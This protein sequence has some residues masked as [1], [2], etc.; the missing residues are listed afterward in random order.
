M[1]LFKIYLFLYL[2]GFLIPQETTHPVLDNIDLPVTI[3]HQGGNKEYPDQSMLAFDNSVNLGIQ[4]LELDIHRTMDS[5]LVIH[6]DASIDRL[7]NQTGMIKEMTWD[8]LQ[9][10]DG[11]YNW[12]IN[13]ENYPYRGKGVQII[14][15]AQLIEKYPDKVYDIEIKQMD[16]PIETDLCAMLRKY[17]LATD[18]VIVASFYDD[19][20]NQFHNICPEVAISLSVKKGTKLYILSRVGLE[21]LLP[22]N[23]VIAQLPLQF[24]SPIG[25]LRLDKRYINAFSK[26]DRQVWVWTVDDPSKMEE[27]LDMGVHGILTDRPDVLMNVTQ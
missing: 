7:T 9:D 10:V 21:R 27:V 4:I 1:T 17:D 3:A 13:G 2:F 19:I 12:T 26:G 15:L 23:S 16:P 14:S 25:E 24:P 11:A 5:V 20:I 6:H 22:I 18:Q 8:E